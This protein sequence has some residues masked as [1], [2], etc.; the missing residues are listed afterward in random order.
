MNITE[1][2]N[3]FRCLHPKKVWNKATEQFITVGCGVCK[4]CLLK[5]SRQGSLL[6]ALEEQDFKYCIFVTLTYNNEFVPLMRPEKRYLLERDEFGRLVQSDSY[7]HDFYDVTERFSAEDD[8]FGSYM[9]SSPID[10]FHLS[11]IQHKVVNKTS[12]FGDIPYL[13]PRDLQLFLKRFRKYLSNYTDE[14]IRYYAVGEYGPVHFR[15][16]WHLLL[17]FNS[18]ETF[19]NYRKCLSLGW[20]KREKVYN[21]RKKRY[22]YKSRPFGRVDASLSRGKCSSY[23][24]SYVNSRVSIP[25]LYTYS[26]IRPFS[27][28]SK[29][30]GKGFYISQ[31][32]KVYENG[33][34]YFDALI[35]EVSGQNANVHPWRSLVATFYPKVARFSE[36]PDNTLLDAYK[37]YSRA[38]FLYQSENIKALSVQIINDLVTTGINAIEPCNCVCD[39][40]YDAKRSLL[41]VIAS[42][43]NLQPLHAYNV[44]MHMCNND[45][46]RYKTL[47]NQIQTL[48]YTSKHFI[49][50][51]CDGDCSYAG[52]RFAQIKEFYS[53]LDYRNLRDWYSSQNVLLEYNGLSV[54]PYLYDNFTDALYYENEIYTLPMFRELLDNVGTEKISQ[55]NSYLDLAYKTDVDFHKKIKHKYLNDANQILCADN[56]PLGA[57]QPFSINVKNQIK[58]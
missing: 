3:P 52:L 6:C 26:A 49:M 7:V 2:N 8:I 11:A 12:G 21:A 28:H 48:L 54:L 51:C 36:M 22:F 31:K 10:D 16:H 53:Y 27:S 39:S 38:K 20:S 14:K 9:F 25:R 23:V 18:E 19:K 47:L 56:T 41:K 30:F 32:K 17:F 24:A 55:L 35:R 29:F 34:S 50:F 46:E 40:L 4:A 58:F 1:V 44:V 42:I 33:P 45:D 13:N 37:T 57:A 43:I 5:K 15:P